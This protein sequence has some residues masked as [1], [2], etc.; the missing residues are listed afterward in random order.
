MVVITGAIRDTSTKTV[1]QELGLESL[2]FRR[3][4][5]K[6]CHFYKKIKNSPRIYL[7]QYLILTGF[8]ISGLDIISLQEKYDMIAITEWNKLDLN[9]GK[10]A[11]L[12][13]FKKK[14][15][16]FIHPCVNSILDIHNPLGIPFITRL[17]LGLSHLHEL[18]FRHCVQKTFNP[19][20]EC[21][22]DIAS[23]T[24]FFFH[25]TN[26]LIPWQTLFQKIR[27]I[28]GSILS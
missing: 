8:I 25:C 21:G 1:Y 14:L 24:H 11:R 4:F 5:R 27:S 15:L 17:R 10:S 2:K 6:L 28:D 26:L 16:N 18:K 7:I 19:L 20:C 12:N 9:I 3:W 22:K 23:T 13:A